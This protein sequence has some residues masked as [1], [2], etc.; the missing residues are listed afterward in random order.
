MTVGLPV[1]TLLKTIEDISRKKILID[2]IPSYR[3]IYSQEEYDQL[4]CHHK[5]LYDNSNEQMENITE[6]TSSEKIVHIED[7]MS[8]LM[9]ICPEYKVDPITNKRIVNFSCDEYYEAFA[10][11]IIRILSCN[12]MIDRLVMV[13]DKSWYTP[14]RK[15]IL[16]LKRLVK[17]NMKKYDDK[18]TF[19]DQGL[20]IDNAIYKFDIMRL[21]MTRNLREAFYEYL[22]SRMKDDDRLG[23][24][25]IVFDF[26]EHGVCFLEQGHAYINM[27]HDTKLGEADLGFIYW[28]LVYGEEYH[29]FFTTTDMDSVPSL[30]ANTYKFK[31][32]AH[33]TLF[34][35][36]CYTHKNW[37][38]C[39]NHP[40]GSMEFQP[41]TCL[42]CRQS[43]DP[44]YRHIN[45]HKT[46]QIM[47]KAKISVQTFVLT[48]ICSGT[49]LYEKENL[50][51]RVGDDCIWKGTRHVVD[52]LGMNPLESFGRF[53]TYVEIVYSL[54][55]HCK[56]RERFEKLK[57]KRKF[58]GEERHRFYGIPDK[59]SLRFAYDEISYMHSYWTAID[60]KYPQ[61]NDTLML[62]KKMARPISTRDITITEP[63]SPI[64]SPTPQQQ[65]KELDIIMESLFDDNEQLP[66]PPPLPTSTSRTSNNT[67]SN[68][69]N[70]RKAKDVDNVIYIKHFKN[71]S[72][73]KNT[74]VAEIKFLATNWFST[75]TTIPTK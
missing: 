28:G 7:I 31:K 41:L 39:T 58:F 36:Y 18:A 63:L 38:P 73:V 43:I 16:Q 24:F 62:T 20:V 26:K 60:G 9:R 22:W 29:L 57:E 40:N 49:D 46:V 35:V 75:M 64:P 33:L 17:S 37:K 52:V 74:D 30:I 50:F 5:Y 70:K 27:D 72:I 1:K 51:Y 65:Q 53:V 12:T 11:Y 8:F 61:G 56:Q 44:K 47:N 14:E 69:N 59:S 10:Q 3:V 54:Y 2:G 45:L 4:T 32:T 25:N 13:C 66:N 6:I 68:N 15:I 48:C 71:D 42:R 19:S 34:Q 67:N 55:Y 23:G 21:M